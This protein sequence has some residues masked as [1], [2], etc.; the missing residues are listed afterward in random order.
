[1]AWFFG[2]TL[3][4]GTGPWEVDN[5][6][7][8]TGAELSANPRWWGGTVPIQQ[9][10][11]QVFADATSE[12]LAFRGGDEDLDPLVVGPKSFASASGAKIVAAPSCLNGMLDMNVHDPG[13]DDVH[14]LPAP[15][16]G[17]VCGIAVGDFGVIT[18]SPTTT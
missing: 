4:M 14:V 11:F 10:S 13:W 2:G 6:D 16:H 9:I 17:D 7:P 12:A 18:L 5:L 1:M 3:I 15:Q 8:T